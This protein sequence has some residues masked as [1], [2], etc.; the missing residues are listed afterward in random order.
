M[1]IGERDDKGVE[2]RFRDW[3]VWQVVL[4]IIVIVIVGILAHKNADLDFATVRVVGSCDL[5]FFAGTLLLGVGVYLSEAQ[6]ESPSVRSNLTIHTQL[7]TAKM[8][9]IVML[10]LFAVCRPD[11]LKGRLFLLDKGAVPIV[12]MQ[13]SL[14]G[15]LYDTANVVMLLACVAFAIYALLKCVELQKR[16]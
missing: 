9:G 11:I 15:W 6:H 14:R 3:L 10:L 4:P 5:L 13:I 8:V 7:E 2:R 12:P 16:G 1:L